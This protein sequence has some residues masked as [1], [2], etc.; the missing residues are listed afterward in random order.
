MHLGAASVSPRASLHA[1]DPEL[2]PCKI[3]FAFQTL[4]MLRFYEHTTVC[5][6]IQGK[7]MM[8][9][10]IGMKFLINVPLWCLNDVYT[11]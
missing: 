10:Y 7:K 3:K 9:S 2:R 11:Y 6:A 8:K 1:N 4:I 5:P